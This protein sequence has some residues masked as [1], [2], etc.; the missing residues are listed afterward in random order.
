M[1]YRGR[2]APSPTGRLHFGSLIAAVAS[3]LCARRAGGRWLLRVEDIDPQREVPGSAQSIIDTLARL[4]MEADEPVMFQSQRGD[5]YQAA[6]DHL[7][8]K[9]LAF[10]CWC[11]RSALAGHGGLHRDGHCVSPPDPSRPPAWRLRVDDRIVRFV[12]ALQGSQT[13]VMRDTAGD[14]VLLRADGFWAYQLACAVDD[15]AQG[16]TEVV[17]GRDLLDSTPRQILLLRLLDMPVPAY[18]HTGLA[19]AAD[20][21]KLSKSASD[22]PLADDELKPALASALHALDLPVAE[23]AT[24]PAQMLRRAV[25]VFDPAQLPRHDL[26]ADWN[27]IAESM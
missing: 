20:G 15:A 26:V 23:R 14:F 19:L 17:R 18:R 4:G 1:D 9:D 25:E 13:E 24:S 10:P 11:S 8:G 16:I 27:G 6:L 22:R 7:H 21:R 12:D 3:W 5:A 2:F